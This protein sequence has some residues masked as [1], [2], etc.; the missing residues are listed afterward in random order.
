MSGV[1]WPGFATG[2]VGIRTPA[3][4]LQWESQAARRLLREEQG[5]STSVAIRLVCLP[6]GPTGWRRNGSNQHYQGQISHELPELPPAAFFRPA[7]S[8]GKGPGERHGVLRHLPQEQDRHEGDHEI[9]FLDWRMVKMLKICPTRFR[10]GKT[11]MALAV[12]L[13]VALASPV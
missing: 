2:E 5:A 10:R 6:G 9:D 11:V 12:V 3:D 8:A 13:M 1:S 4:H 7:R